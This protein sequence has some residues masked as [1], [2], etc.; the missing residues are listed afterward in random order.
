[1][2]IGWEEYNYFINCTAVQLMIFPKQTKWRKGILNTNVKWNCPRGTR[3]KYEQKH[4][5]LVGNLAG[6]GFL[7]ENLAGRIQFCH[8]NNKQV[9][10]RCCSYNYELDSPRRLVQFWQNSKHHSY[11]YSWFHIT[12]PRMLRTLFR[13]SLWSS[14][15]HTEIHKPVCKQISQLEALFTYVLVNF[16]MNFWTSQRSSERS[17]QHLRKSY[18]KSTV[19]PICTRHRMITYTKSLHQVYQH[20]V[21]Q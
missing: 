15:V 16:I 20:C 7:V 8:A 9:I 13:T 17:S 5:I 11:Y 1:M 3:W 18:M 4:Q 19:I 14:K 6:L 10:M 12:F 2:L 21:F